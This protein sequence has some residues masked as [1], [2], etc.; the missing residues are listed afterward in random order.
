MREKNNSHSK[1]R[2]TNIWIT[3][4]SYILCHRLLW[5][6]T[7]E[8]IEQRER[9][10]KYHLCSHFITTTHTHTTHTN[11]LFTHGFKKLL[12]C[13]DK[14]ENTNKL[15]KVFQNLSHILSFG[16]SPFNPVISI[17]VSSYN[18]VFMPLRSLVMNISLKSIFAL[19]PTCHF[20]TPK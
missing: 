9:T 12:L 4:I 11:Q 2:R 8:H 20:G 19:S 16:W 1:Q 7:P 14:N 6:L 17:C 15:L 18:V 13:L 5:R 10:C 3:G